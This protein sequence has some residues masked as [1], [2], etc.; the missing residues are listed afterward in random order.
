MHQP[1]LTLSQRL[2]NLP[3]E[4]HYMIIDKYKQM[5]VFPELTKRNK[6]TLKILNEKIN[7]LDV[8]PED[9]VDVSNI[10]LFNRIFNQRDSE[11]GEYFIYLN[12]CITGFIEHFFSLKYDEREK[13]RKTV[14]QGHIYKP[15]NPDNKPNINPYTNSDDYISLKNRDV[16]IDFI[17]RDNILFNLIDPDDKHHGATCIWCIKN[18]MIIIFGTYE[19]RLKHWIE[20]IHSHFN[21]K[22]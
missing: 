6:N 22:Q 12:K 19:Q 17:F 11:T 4:L 20:L 16:F 15:F 2:T 9:L 8:D 3:F 13:W 7:E 21:L 5:Y 18:I 10:C 14:L 1:I